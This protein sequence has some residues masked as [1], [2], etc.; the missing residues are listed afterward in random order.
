MEPDA[1]HQEDDADL[2]E[3]VGDVLVGDVARRER[4]DKDAGDQIADERRKLE[5]VRQHAEAEGEPKTDGK[6]RDERRHMRH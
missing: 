6:R 1:E 4:T 2:G 5:A 3:L